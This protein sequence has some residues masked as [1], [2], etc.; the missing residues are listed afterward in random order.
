MPSRFESVGLL[1]RGRRDLRVTVDGI[2]FDVRPRTND[3][4]LISP[5]HEPITT[6]WFQVGPNEVVVDV[7]AHV[8]RYALMAAAKGARVIAIEPDPTSFRLLEK[9]VKL[10]GPSNVV[11]VTNALTAMPG[12]L[13]LVIAPARN[14][15]TSFVKG[16]GHGEDLTPPGNVTIRVQGRPSTTS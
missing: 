11:L 16:A 10:N 9:N 5:K 6:D 12:T 14:T 15:G 13:Q 7:G 1:T 2:A 3:L 4:D 8:G